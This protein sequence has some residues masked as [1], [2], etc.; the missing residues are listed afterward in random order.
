METRLVRGLTP[1]GPIRHKSSK[2]VSC[3]DRES[4]YRYFK[5]KAVFL[6]YDCCIGR[7]TGS[8]LFQNAALTECQYDALFNY[9]YISAFI[10]HYTFYCR[11]QKVLI[12]SN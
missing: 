1:Q 9:F 6:S 5:S 11:Y 7:N 3:S 4:D 10:L 12:F 2:S 8:L